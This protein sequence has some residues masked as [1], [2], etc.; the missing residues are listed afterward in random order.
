MSKTSQAYTIRKSN[1]LNALARLCSARMSSFE[2]SLLPPPELWPKTREMADQCDE[3]IY[4]TRTLL[5]T[6]VKEGKVYISSHPINNSLRWFI[7]TE[8]ISRK[9]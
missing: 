8:R 6:L 9:P 2:G 7:C 3:N 1:M 5:L 4:T